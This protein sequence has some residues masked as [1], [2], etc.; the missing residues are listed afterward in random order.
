ME[1]YKFLSNL[2]TIASLLS[3]LSLFNLPVYPLAII[4]SSLSTNKSEKQVISLELYL[5]SSIFSPE[6]LNITIAAW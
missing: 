6:S 2:T 3:T 5:T 4:L 1:Y